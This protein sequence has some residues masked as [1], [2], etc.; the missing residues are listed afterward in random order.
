M[1]RSAAPAE[2]AVKR[3]N[4]RS[5]AVARTQKKVTETKP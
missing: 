2:P 4:E 5:S 1:T 3:W